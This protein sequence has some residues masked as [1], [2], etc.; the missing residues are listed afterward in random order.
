MS[1]APSKTFVK[2]AVVFFMPLIAILLLCI[3]WGIVYLLRKSSSQN[4][5]KNLTL[6]IVTVLF[7]IYPSMISISFGLINCY[8]LNPGER[9]LLRDLQIRCWSGDH[10]RWVYI[11]AIPMILFWVIGI[12]LLGFRMIF[13][14]RKELHMEENLERYKMMYQGLRDKVFY[15][16]FLNL[17]RK[18][19]LISINVF[20]STIAQEYKVTQNS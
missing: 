18:L 15:W 9:W 12:P 5:R 6:S 3:F 8:E 20:M 7:L 13:K 4:V 11:I 19:L 1:N 2:A 14:R 10:Y 17:F 16:E